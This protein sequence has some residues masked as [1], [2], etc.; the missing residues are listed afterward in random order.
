MLM[1]NINGVTYHSDEMSALYLKRNAWH[2]SAAGELLRTNAFRVPTSVVLISEGGSLTYAEW[3]ESSEKL[4]AALLELG[5][6]PGDSAIFQMGT[7]AE[8]AI[9]LFGCF[10]AGIVPVC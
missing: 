2:E 4:A 9:A 10:K 5:L 1:R 8:T 7:V 6:C 3:D